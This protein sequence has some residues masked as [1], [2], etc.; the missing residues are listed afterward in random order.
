MFKARHCAAIVPFFFAGLFV[1]TSAQA[2]T[3]SQCKTLSQEA[4]SATPSCA[5]VDGY[6]RKDGRKVSAYCRKA[7]QRKA[8]PSVG[9]QADPGVKAIRKQG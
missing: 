6:T 5:W 2:A 3:P 9:K 4:C 1:V 7:P 8:S